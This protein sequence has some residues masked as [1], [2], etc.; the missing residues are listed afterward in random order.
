M[1]KQ[2]LKGNE[3]IAEAAVRNGCRY[4]FGYPITPQS[5][6]P[7]YMSARLPE[8]GG[9]FVQAESEVAAINMVYGAGAAGGRTMT[10]SSSPGVS[11]KQE[12]LSYIAASDVPCVIVN[13]VRSGPG[14][15]GIQPAQGDYFQ[16]VKGGGHGDYRLIVFAPSDVQ[17]AVD[18]TYKAFDIADEYRVP[19]MILG[20]GVLGQMMEGVELPPMRA[21]ESLP[22]KNWA[23]KG[24]NGQGERRIIN[25]LRIQPD[26]LENYLKELFQR[27]EVIKQKEARAEV[28]LCDDAEVILTAYGTPARICKSAVDKLRA[29]Y[30]IKAGLIRPVTLF[31]FP[32]GEYRR[33][34]KADNVKKFVTVE[35]SM[36]Q[37][38]EDVKLSVNGLKPVE[39][40]GRSGGNIMND[41]EVAAFIAGGLK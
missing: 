23:L 14:L 1:A 36:G 16:A 20:D 15:G 9:V 18:L 31:P 7:E 37:M 33:Y 35:L 13:I 12:G 17:E 2:L 24:Y 28:Y 8:V 11:L 25:S 5:E 32:D 4:Y 27:Y 34:A 22:Q 10:S 30:G 6:I 21:L 26:D 19:V 29:H 3:A 41:E 38:I 40:Y 39:F